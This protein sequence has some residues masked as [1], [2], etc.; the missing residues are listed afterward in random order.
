[1]SENL[2]RKRKVNNSSSAGKKELKYDP[3]SLAGG[4]T[5][6]APSS[7]SSF[8]RIPTGFSTSFSSSSTYPLPNTSSS[9]GLNAS[10]EASCEEEVIYQDENIC[11]L[12]PKS[13]RAKKT[14]VEVVHAFGYMSPIVGTT[15]T[16]ANTIAKEGLKTSKQLIMNKYKLNKT[17][18]NLFNKTIHQIY[19]IDNEEL[20]SPVHLNE[21]L[22]KKLES[23]NS[24]HGRLSFYSSDP[25]QYQHV[26]LRPPSSAPYTLDATGNIISAGNWRDFIGK[27]NEHSFFFY[28]KTYKS[29]LLV[30]A[31]IDDVSEGLV[32]L[33]VDPELT[34]VYS[35]DAK[36]SL[37]NV[38]K[39]TGIL[40][41]E[42]FDQIEL[43]SLFYKLSRIKLSDLLDYF[44]KN[45][46]IG[47]STNEIIATPPSGFIPQC[48]FEKILKLESK[49]EGGY[50][51]LDYR[52]NTVFQDIELTENDKTIREKIIKNNNF[53]LHKSKFLDDIINSFSSYYKKEINDQM[54]KISDEINNI[55]KEYYS[56]IN[57]AISTIFNSI[58]ANLKSQIE[59]RATELRQTKTKSEPLLIMGAKLTEEDFDVKA[60]EV[61]KIVTQEKKK[62]GLLAA[63]GKLSYV[64]KLL[65]DMFE[66]NRY[67][68]KFKYMG[69]INAALQE[70]T[71]I[72]LNTI[73]N[74][75]IINIYYH[76]Q[77]KGISINILSKPVQME[78]LKIQQAEITKFIP[79]ALKGSK[80]EYLKLLESIMEKIFPEAYAMIQ[81]QKALLASKQASS[82]GA[83]AQGGRR[84]IRKTYKNRKYYKKTYKCKH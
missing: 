6:L 52:T 73:Y 84:K 34:Y 78:I 4:P 40:R 33:R 74:F 46:G 63:Q 14:G 5:L 65:Y 44:Q 22:Y 47:D 62:I 37:A 59:I 23:N 82:K 45:P 39:E 71:P 25:Q 75:I 69:K 26:Y 24:V 79:K 1:M 35:E 64:D 50:T 72:E 42:I 16:L 30:A 76:L 43:K 27:E 54:K 83:S 49:R 38:D 51:I 77:N 29:I 56:R 18:S 48:A 2:N 8:S 21:N 55:N 15:Y 17:K 53:K 7:F 61:Y 9:S 19:N 11:I 80:S 60:K 68:E 20:E 70:I 28:D 3:T 32:T 36:N 67:D 57:S 12:N 13:E 31:D 41:P 10:S 66:T 58:I 81:K